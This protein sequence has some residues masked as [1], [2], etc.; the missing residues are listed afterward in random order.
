MKIANDIIRWGDDD[1]KLFSVFQNLKTALLVP[2]AH[3]QY[4][5]STPKAPGSIDSTAQTLPSP[6]ARQQRFRTDCLERDDQ[7]CV[8]TGVVD[9]SYLDEHLELLD[10]EPE[11][12]SVPKEIAESWAVL[13]KCFPS[14][15]EVVDISKI[16]ETTNGLS[17]HTL[18]HRAF[19]LFKLAFEATDEPNTYKMKTYQRIDSFVPRMIHQDRIVRFNDSKMAPHPPTPGFWPLILQLLKF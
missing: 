19:G 1:E 5:L 18:I 7:R 17:L 15:Q 9:S 12:S 14:L 2:T 10:H 13:Y 16:N 11:G 8:A 6:L 4:Q 3:H